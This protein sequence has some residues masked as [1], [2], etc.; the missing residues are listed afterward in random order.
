MHVELVKTFRIESAHRSR[1][2]RDPDHLHGHSYE[3]G[4]VVQ[5][6]CDEKLGWLID[7]AEISKHVEPL[8]RQLDHFDLNDVL[9]REEVYEADVAEWISERLAPKLPVLK[10]VTVGVIG[11]CLFRAEPRDADAKLD[12][13]TRVRFGF[14]AAHALPHLPE[15]HKC[16]RMH[17]HSFVVEAAADDVE[18]LTPAL[19]AVYDRLA[20]RCLNRVEGLD[21]PTSEN[22]ARWI[23][24]VLARDHERLRAVVVAETCTARCIY[25]GGG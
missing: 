5:G 12:L 15:D 16:R 14:E 18:A 4:V 7:Y 3:I 2:G 1:M 25:R 6:P 11:P 13:P 10:E 19:E 17:G 24:D 8:M 9:G 22:V 21:N 20:H 23:W